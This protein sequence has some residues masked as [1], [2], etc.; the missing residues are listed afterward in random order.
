MG[1]LTTIAGLFLLWRYGPTNL[2]SIPRQIEPP[3]LGGRDGAEP[4][5]AQLVSV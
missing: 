2:A 5:S 1:G 4:V 3:A